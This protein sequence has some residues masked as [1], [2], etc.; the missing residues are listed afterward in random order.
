[1][2]SPVVKSPVT[3]A[4][5]VQLNIRSRFAKERATTIARSTGMTTTQVVEEALRAYVPPADDHLPPGLVRRGRLLVGLAPGRKLTLEEVDATFDA[6][7]EE[8][9]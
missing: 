5:S 2:L 6:V 1:M 7:R 9:G 3:R 8:R 4:Q